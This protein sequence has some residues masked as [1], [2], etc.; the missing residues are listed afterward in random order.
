MADTSKVIDLDRLARFKTKQ[1]AANEAKF[2]L[3][4][5]GGSIA[6]ADKAGIVKPG[7]DFDITEDGTIS[8]Y[9]KIA[10]TSFTCAP[11]QAERGATVTDVELAWGLNKIPSTLTL[12]DAAQEPTSKG[13]SLKGVNLT[14]NKQWTL[15]ATDAR[16]ASASRTAGITFYDKRHWFTATDLAAAGITDELINQAA[17]EYATSRA[18]TFT[19]TAG[20]GQ[21]IYYA[22]PASWGTPTF[23]VGGFEGGFNLLTTFDHTNA[24]GAT[25]SYAVWKSTNANLGKTTVEVS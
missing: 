21:H 12:D 9:S 24:S 6:T 23:K 10:V 11:S 20:D 8:L 2:A 19:L 18:K 3:K 4:G 13:A 25:V 22:F 16:N 7:A 14:A 17:G 5:E 15:K 1:D